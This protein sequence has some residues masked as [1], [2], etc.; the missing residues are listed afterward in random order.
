MRAGGGGRGRC[1]YNNRLKGD[2][3]VVVGGLNGEGGGGVGGLGSN[4]P[5]RLLNME[6]KCL[7]PNKSWLSCTNPS[8]RVNLV[9]KTYSTKDDFHFLFLYRANPWG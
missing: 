3:V 7:E 5:T 4:S 8:I 6:R 1:V 2:V 9:K